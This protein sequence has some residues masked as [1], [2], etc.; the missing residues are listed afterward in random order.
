MKK[1]TS[2]GIFSSE[3]RKSCS[4]RLHNTNMKHNYSSLKKKNK[5]QKKQKENEKEK[6]LSKPDLKIQ[7]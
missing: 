1:K 2:L 3:L 6:I 5:I 4:D 7:Q